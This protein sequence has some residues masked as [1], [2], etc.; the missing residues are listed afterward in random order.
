MDVP[1][2][3][4]IAVAPAGAYAARPRLFAALEQAFPVRFTAESGPDVAGTIVIADD[5]AR[6]TA[7][8]GLPALVVGDMPA[9]ESPVVPV[10][11]A[12]T[13]RLDRRLC[14]ITLHDRPAGSALASSG[15]VLAVAG[16]EAVWSRESGAASVDRVRSVL[17]ELAEGDV[18]YGLL[19]QRAIAAV[20]LIEFLRARTADCG[21]RPPPLRA[22]FVFDDPNLRWR[23]YGHIDYPEL[24]AHADA[25]GY[26]AVMAMIPLDAAW[27]HRPTVS[28]FARR[29]DRLS[30]VFHGNDHVR[31]ELLAPGD[32]ATALALAA[33]AIRRIERF[34]RRHGLRVDRVMMPPHGLCS[35]YTALALSAVGFDA[36]CAIH[37]APW[38]EERP[39]SPPLVAWN[40]A[41]FVG[42]CAVIPR[43][44]LCSTVADLALRAYLDHPLVVYGHH[45]DVAGG[46][47]PLAE[48][49]ALINRFGDVRWTSMDEIARTNHFHRFVDGRMVVRPFS[50]RVR[51]DV[52]EGTDCVVVEAPRPMDSTVALR[53]WSVG[54]GPVHPFDAPVPLPAGSHEIRLRAVEEIDP[55]TVAAP[56]WSP[57]PR[58][59]RAATEVRD[60]AA[61]LRRRAA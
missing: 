36:L 58:V 27:P 5:A 29:A 7:A 53:G 16:A 13:A 52:S 25:H 41:G 61:P 54:G 49:A 48:A 44:A 60:R 43:D 9:G 26:H 50:R 32:D 56:G 15:E 20:A 33:Q 24:V 12:D 8:D 38:T 34:E 22:A 11:I 28:L 55:H 6:S 40:P 18:L 1:H 39:A 19:S 47:E 2:T 59:R 46:L 31:G 30:L 10:Q 37:P 21:W 42:G 4:T 3:I 51:L 17:P 35:R 14:G 45:D 57:W 23:S